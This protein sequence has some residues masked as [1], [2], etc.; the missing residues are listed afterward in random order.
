MAKPR[1]VYDSEAAMCADFCTW[2]R[3]QGWVPYA[4]TAGWDI[5]LVGSDGTQIGVHAKLKF[6]MQVLGQV[7]HSFYD[8]V[9]GSTGEPDFRAV[10][11][12]DRDY[13]AAEIAGALG[14]QHFFPSQFNRGLF[15][16]D[17]SGKDRYSDARW[18][19]WNPAKR[20]KLPE[21][22]P[23]V[24]AGSPAPV[25][26]TEWK[27]KALRICATLE[28]RGKVTRDDFKRHGNR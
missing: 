5:L 16:P 13:T 12:P 23:D 17:L 7:V 14:L 22:I 3:Q 27:I 6:N 10:L 9:H 25:Q 19:F 15:S 24:A 18:H 21:Y 1:Q 11:T 8:E 20:C 4:E 26:L 28:S 2:A